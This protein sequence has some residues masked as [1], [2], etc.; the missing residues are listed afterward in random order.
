MLSRSL[1]L[2]PFSVDN[3]ESISLVSHRSSL[4]QRHS[5]RC[6]ID[7][8]LTIVLTGK[9]GITGIVSVSLTDIG[10]KRHSV[11]DCVQLNLLNVSNSIAIIRADDVSLFNESLCWRKLCHNCNLSK[12]LRRSSVNG[13][14]DGRAT[15]PIAGPR[16]QAEYNRWWL[17]WWIRVNKIRPYHCVLKDMTEWTF[18]QRGTKTLLVREWEKDS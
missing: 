2:P 4:R 1:N 9:A 8:L 10:S 5:L 12:V 15:Y 17:K 11:F 7:R 6:F 14:K 16:Q 18:Q 13:A 3:K